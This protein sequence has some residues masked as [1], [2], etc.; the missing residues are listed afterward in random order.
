MLEHYLWVRAMEIWSQRSL[1]SYLGPPMWALA[2]MLVLIVLNSLVLFGLLILFIHAAH[3]LATNTTMIENWEIER[4]AALVERARKNGGWVYTRGGQKMRIESQEFPYD[5][6][7][8]K[9]LVQGMGTWNVLMWFMPFG[10]APRID[11]AGGYEVNGF[12]DE[13]KVW[14]PPDP[15]KLGRAWKPTDAIPGGDMKGFSYATLDEHR[16]AFRKRQEADYERQKRGFDSQ[17]ASGFKN[18]VMDLIDEEAEDGYESENGADVPGNET[19]TNA[20]GET[21]G[22]FGVDEDEDD[23]PLGELIRR[24]KARA[25][26]P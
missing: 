6:G 9:N 7:V 17:V 22:D 3:S 16:E 15:E 14:P 1:P 13:D 20:E 10:G 12:E 25:F 4:H 21:L 2:H 11:D 8:W 26:E 5:I 24:R 23:I 18:E 19:W